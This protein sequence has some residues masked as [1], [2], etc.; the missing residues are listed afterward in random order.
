VPSRKTQ[1]SI[2]LLNLPAGHRGRI[3]GIHGAPEHVHRI[4]EFG[5]HR[6]AII[7]MF[8]RGNPCIFRVAGEK[9][10]FRANDLVD[11]LVEPAAAV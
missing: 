2:N 5:L 3:V 11:I 1:S 10:C 9:V 7:E 8:R 6:G 4:E